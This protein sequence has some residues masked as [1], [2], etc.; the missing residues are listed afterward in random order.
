[1]SNE[2]KEG[3]SWEGYIEAPLDLA[4][5]GDSSRAA[6]FDQ[7]R[8]SIEELIQRLKPRTVGCLGSGFLNDIPIESLFHTAHE[9]YFIDWIAN[10]S[11]QGVRHRIL[12]ETPLVR[13]LFCACDQP[14][15]FCEAFSGRAAETD[16]VCTSFCPAEGPSLQCE[17]YVP[18][19]EPRF[20][21]ADVTAGRGSRFGKRIHRVVAQSNTPK[22]AFQRA[23]RECSNTFN[24]RDAMP[25]K[26]NTFDFVTSSLVV[27]QFDAEPYT[28]FARLLEEKFGREQILSKENILLSLMTELRSELFRLQMEGH[29]AEIYRMLNKENGKAYFSVEFFR[30]LPTGDDFFMVHESPQ[31]LTS[32]DRY[33]HFDFA[34]ISPDQ[35][36]QAYSMGA[37]N[38]VVQSFVLAPKTEAELAV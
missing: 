9:I 29:A 30:S 1:M 5:G 38:S 16:M 17:N 15:R 20:I 8:Q 36:L 26:A 23:I 19:T 32:L 31:V 7:Q 3:L 37:G 18:G 25:V 24:I 33:F 22:Q 10:V 13:C 11:M 12:E 14:R 4:T 28:F 34:S 6:A 21:Q 27:S 35:S 2:D